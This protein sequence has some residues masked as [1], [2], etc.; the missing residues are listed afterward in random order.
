MFRNSVVLRQ[1][2]SVVNVK[3]VAFQNH[4]KRICEF[5]HLKFISYELI[6][7]WY[8]V[9]SPYTNELRSIAAN[10]FIENKQS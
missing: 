7:L 9:I 10:V 6:F 2:L 1:T 3:S 5:C 8:S 4:E